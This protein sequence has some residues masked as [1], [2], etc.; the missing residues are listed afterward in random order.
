MGEDQLFL[1]DL[2]IFHRRVQF[3]NIPIYT[4]FRNIEGQLTSR[5][6]NIVEISNVIPETFLIFE[7]ATGNEKKLIGIMLVRQIMTFIKNRGFDGILQLFCGDL[8]YIPRLR[9]KE[10]FTLFKS[11]L[12]V[13]KFKLVRNV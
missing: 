7:E 5:A 3:F 2:G 9:A 13:C 4:Y 11:M 12:I 10:F 8:K 1:L 6:E